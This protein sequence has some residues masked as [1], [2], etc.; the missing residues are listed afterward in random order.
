MTGTYPKEFTH[1]ELVELGRAWCIK[2][3]SQNAKHGHAGCS[4]VITEI[5]ANTWGME[6]PDVLGFC[7]KVTILIECKTSRA[8][9][10]RDKDKIFRNPDVANLAIGSQR[11]Y[12]TPLGLI[13]KDEVPEGWGLLEVHR[14]RDIH[15]SVFA[16]VQEKNW[17]SE[18]NIL[19]SVLR[20]LNVEKN[21]HI[22]IQRYTTDSFIKGGPPSKKRATFYIEDEKQSEQTT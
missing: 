2:P 18:Q 16:K 6:T 11:W 17:R 20:R 9:F 19:I 22:A 1:K 7:N 12:L 4:V 13:K 21:D 5:S 8:D 14:C 10:L 15:T 3:Y